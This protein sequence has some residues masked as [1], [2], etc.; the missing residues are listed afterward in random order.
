MD[1]ECKAFHCVRGEV[2]PGG[3]TVVVSGSY[4]TVYGTES[5]RCVRA[6]L[7]S[8]RLHTIFLCKGQ[9]YKLSCNHWI[10]LC[11]KSLKCLFVGFDSTFLC[12]FAHA[13]DVHTTKPST[14]HR[15]KSSNVYRTAP[16]SE[17]KAKPRV[18][19]QS[20]PSV[21]L[22]SARAWC[23]ALEGPRPPSRFLHPPPCTTTQRQFFF[24]LAR[25]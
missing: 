4:S 15:S 24:F 8:Y 18:C 11:K 3:R 10:S 13:F 25:Y 1:G 16:F 7:S 20:L 19:L 22:A 12:V 21:S 9:R 6:R 14:V 2:L 5:F 23:A 17:H